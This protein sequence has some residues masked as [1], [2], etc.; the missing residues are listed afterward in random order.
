MHY[1][2]WNILLTEVCVIG[3]IQL[4]TVSF[5]KLLLIITFP[6]EVS[7]HRAMN[8][9]SSVVFEVSSS[10]NRQRVNISKTVLTHV[11]ESKH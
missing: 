10:I 5:N 2:I 6:S 4:K 8:A 3:D 11:T 1:G 7:V 9:T